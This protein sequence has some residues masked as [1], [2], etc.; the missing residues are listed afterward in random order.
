MQK[1]GQLRIIRCIP[2]QLKEFVR[3][4]GAPEPD[5][6]DDG[7]AATLACAQPFG[8]VALD[9]K[10]GRRIAH[11]DY[12]AMEVY[13]TLDL[14]FSPECVRFFGAAQVT[15][16]AKDAKGIARMRILPEW[17]EFMATIAPDTRPLEK[18]RTGVPV[19]P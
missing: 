8:S 1:L 16:A 10:K 13:C 9:E 2:D 18:P 7:E 3:L 15:K 17:R 14:L 12:P 11:R 19:Q 4:V 6:L 5:D